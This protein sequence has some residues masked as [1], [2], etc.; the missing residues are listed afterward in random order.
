M[1]SDYNGWSVA[2][3]FAFNGT[4][5]EET[6]TEEILS[7]KDHNNFSIAYI[8]SG[9]ENF[10]EWAKRRRNILLLENG[11]YVVHQLAV[12]GAVP[13]SMMTPEILQLKTSDMYSVLDILI[14][15]RIQFRNLTCDILL[16]S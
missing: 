16:L 12:R 6:I 9:R 7:L 15:F 3:C 13:L 5:P 10:P 4:L 14:Q 8:L 2:H 11:H 1:I